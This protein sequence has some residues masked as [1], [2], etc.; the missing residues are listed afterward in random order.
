MNYAPRERI[1]VE[2]DF[3]RNTT[4]CPHCQVINWRES[5]VTRLL[6]PNGEYVQG[7]GHAQVWVPAGLEYW[8]NGCGWKWGGNP[9]IIVPPWK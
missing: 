2:E 3:D 7:Y 4:Q 1:P 6:N 5:T 8:C 9:T